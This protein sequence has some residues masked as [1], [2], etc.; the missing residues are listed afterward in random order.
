MN[1][2]LAVREQLGMALSKT[3]NWAKFLY[4]L[5]LLLSL[6]AP[7]SFLFF[8]PNAFRVLSWLPKTPH[9]PLFL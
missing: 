8:L 2:F 7:F 4:Q 6:L 5:S 9:A 1:M 3:M